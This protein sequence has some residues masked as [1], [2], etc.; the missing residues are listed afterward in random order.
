MTH[1]ELVEFAARWLRG[2]RRCALVAEERS[3]QKSSESPDAIGWGPRGD[4]VL[5]ECKVSRVDF[6]ADRRKPHRAG[7]GMGLE[8][9]YLTDRG[10][11]RPEEITAGWGL[12]EVRN[13]RVFRAVLARSRVEIRG[14]IA[15][16]ELP[17]LVA[18]SRR[19]LFNAV[20]GI[21]L[22]DIDMEAGHV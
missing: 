22:G 8:R 6:L 17:L 21:T 3:C 14:E 10:L 16:L 12:L 19:A 7:A 20:G 4:S 9:W 15:L 1:A 13:G 5:V 18:L 11:M 2:T